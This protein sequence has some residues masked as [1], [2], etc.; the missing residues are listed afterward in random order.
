MGKCGTFNPLRAEPLCVEP[1]CV[2]HF[3]HVDSLRV[4]SLRLH[5]EFQA[6]GEKSSVDSFLSNCAQTR[7]AKIA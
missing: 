3:A 1:L 2:I 4:D 6:P 5:K 7:K